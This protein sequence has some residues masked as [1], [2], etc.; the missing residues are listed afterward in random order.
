Y[1]SSERSVDQRLSE[2]V[3][4][5]GI[6]LS[7][8]SSRKRCRLWPGQGPPP[9]DR[10]VLPTPWRGRSSGSGIPTDDCGI[11]MRRGVMPKKS[12][13]PA[14]PRRGR[15][16]L[17][18]PTPEYLA[19]REEIVAA[20][21]RTFRARGY[22]SASLDDV[23]AELDLRKASLYHYVDSKAHLLYL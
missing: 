4:R 18:E 8:S 10:R 3:P 7:R 9:V 17:T 15:P 14:P 23:A 13:Q 21:A 11:A 16:R 12:K 6:D 5:A 2:T 20:A 19:R 1:S 22:D